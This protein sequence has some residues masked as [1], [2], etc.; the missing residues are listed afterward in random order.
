M[1]HLLIIELPGD[2]DYDILQ[3]AIDRGDDF[4]FLCADLGRYRKQTDVSLMLDYAR[5]IIEVRPFDYM[6]VQRRVLAIDNVH[7]FDAV[8]CLIDA[9][10]REAA[11]LALLLGLP[12]LN[13]MTV[14]LLRNRFQLRQ[15]LAR[16]GIAQAD[17]A[18][19]TCAET[20]RD[21]VARLAFPVRIRPLDAYDA[22]TVRI[23]RTGADLAVLLAPLTAWHADNDTLSVDIAARR[24]ML[25]ERCLSGSYLGCDT[26]SVQGCHTL[27]GVH[28]HHMFAPPSL[29]IRGGTF[30]PN[31]GQFTAL[32]Q[33]AFAVLEALDFDCGAAHLE[34]ILG[35]NG[36]H[37]LDL[38]PRLVG[39][40]LPRLVGRSLGRSVHADLIALH[41]GEQPTHPGRALSVPQVGVTR[42]LAAD[43]LGV[44]D[45]VDLP[46]WDDPRVR[47]V[48]ILKHPGDLVGPPF[49]NADRLGYLVTCAPT[50]LEAESI[51]DR[52]VA[53]SRVHLR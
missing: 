42:W 35:V 48:D 4:T 12:H 27:L 16:H 39:S 50:A 31:Q 29:A 10:Q 25:V 46:L 23:L 11:R 26:F 18:L 41:T 2:N 44:L 17:F 30:T 47:C 53:D 34:I 1:A 45:R 28:E 51:A 8:I 3:A 43:H 20:L 5:E 7:G 40:R 22:S 36:P 14:D 49:D 15:R 32:E 21:A 37:L 9:R 19:A 24:P 6:E 52:F 38:N 33:Y 13:V